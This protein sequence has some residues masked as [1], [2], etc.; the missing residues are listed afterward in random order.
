MGISQ[1]VSLKAFHS[2]SDCKKLLPYIFTINTTN[3]EIAVRM[4]K[5]FIL[6]P[7][8]AF[9]R[10]MTMHI[11]D[12]VSIKHGLRTADCGVGIKYGLGIRCELRTEYKTRTGY[13]TRTT[14]YVNKNSFR[15]VKLT[16][17]ESGLAKTVVPAL[18]FPWL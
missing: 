17:M 14:D 11:V 1:A 18:T 8:R 13:K 5:L 12:A 7:F 10:W 4:R 6:L 16:E 15:R 2:I 3:N 9:H